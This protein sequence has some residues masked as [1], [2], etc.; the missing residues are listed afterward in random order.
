MGRVGIAQFHSHVGDA[1]PGPREK[2]PRPFP[3]ALVDQGF[4][5]GAVIGE[6]SLERARRLAE[7]L[8]RLREGR[9]P[10][11]EAG[12]DDALHGSARL[13]RPEPDGPDAGC[14]VPF[15]RA[16]R[17]GDLPADL[18][19]PQLRPALAE[20]VT[21]YVAAQELDL[22]RP[23][24]RANLAQLHLK[25]GRADEAERD[26][27][28][29]LRLDPTAGLIAA[30]FAEL[31]RRT[32]REDQAEDILRGVLAVDPR[33]DAA[34]RALGL[35]LVRQKRPDE[36][37]LRLAQA[38]EAEPDNPRYAFVHAVALRSARQTQQARAI[39]EANLSR[40]AGHVDTAV[41]L[42]QEAL[43]T[44][45]KDRAAELAKRLAALRPDD[46]RFEGVL[47]DLGR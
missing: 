18:L 16:S 10:F 45:E 23:E 41:A 28:A 46:R 22:D 47:R 8:G 4:V 24:A 5:V 14:V 40:H 19:S 38:S 1:G 21:A 42:L 9:R 11:R 29:A 7:D 25:Q 15:G 3:S 37:L 33:S 43:Q 2:R 6:A 34:L 27:R 26:Y 35:S 39:L 32:G 13:A 44:R 17:G 12:P 30:Q 31:L 36:A 20:A